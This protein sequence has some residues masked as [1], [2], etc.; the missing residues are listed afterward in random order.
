MPTMPM[1]PM[2]SI[3]CDCVIVCY[4]AKSTT[5]RIPSQ[6]VCILVHCHSVTKIS[7]LNEHHKTCYS[8]RHGIQI[9][10]FT[11]AYLE[12]YKISCFHISRVIEQRPHTIICANN[13]AAVWI[14]FFHRKSSFFY[15]NSLFFV[16]DQAKSWFR[17]KA[18][19]SFE[20]EG[21]LRSNVHILIMYKLISETV[22]TSWLS[23]RRNFSKENKDMYLCIYLVFFTAIGFASSFA[24][25]S[26]NCNH[27]A[28]H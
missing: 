18:F 25:Y 27:A 20:R 23:N 7:R 24:C 2:L 28:L 3:A 16:N 21:S 12:C 9:V 17:F 10:F 13:F 26:I 1:M 22:S 19:E 8:L 15:K 5:Y 6:F 14:F 4:C 11:Q